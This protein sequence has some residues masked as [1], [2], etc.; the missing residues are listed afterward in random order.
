MGSSVRETVLSRS[1]S[2]KKHRLRIFTD[3]RDYSKILNRR[4]R[5]VVFF[6]NLTTPAPRTEICCRNCEISSRF[7]PIFR[8]VLAINPNPGRLEQKACSLTEKRERKRE[9]PNLVPKLS[10]L[11]SRRLNLGLR[12]LTAS[13][14]GRIAIASSN[15]N[16]FRAE[17]GF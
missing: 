4:L 1:S 6:P 2:S 3:A 7:F 8:V 11:Q 14:G 9:K 13:Q 5:L 15:L 16:Q 10:N 17:E 12:V